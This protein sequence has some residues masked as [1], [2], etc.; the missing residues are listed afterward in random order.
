MGRACLGKL[1]KHD[2]HSVEKHDRHSIEKD[3]GMGNGYFGI[4][5][6]GTGGED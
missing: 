4:D 2:R 5:G 3:D 6:G 1:K